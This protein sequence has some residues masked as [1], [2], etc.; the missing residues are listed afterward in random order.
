MLLR[1]V[2]LDGKP[3]TSLMTGATGVVTIEILHEDI[4][5]Y[6]TTSRD[7]V[8]GIELSSVVS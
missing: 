7:H 5:S 8:L 2:E 3:T 4:A 1:S 6:K